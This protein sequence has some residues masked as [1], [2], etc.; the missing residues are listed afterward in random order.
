MTRGRGGIFFWEGGRV[1]TGVDQKFMDL[2][3]MR[4]LLEQMGMLVIRV[5]E[6]GIILSI[7]CT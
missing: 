6:L 2:L 4:C 7:I 5:L 3:H 1:G